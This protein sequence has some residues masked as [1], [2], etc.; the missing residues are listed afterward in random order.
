MKRACGLLCLL[1]SLLAAACSPTSGPGSSSQAPPERVGA[2]RTLIFVH[3]GENLSYA[4]KEIQ[5][6]GGTTAGTRTAE[7][8]YLFNANLIFLDD[9]SLPYAVLAESVPEFGTSS[10]QLLPD[11]KMEI[12]Y[13][14]KPN[15]TWHDGQ[16][17]T[18][19]DWAFAWRVYSN[20][21]FGI[22]SSGGLRYIDDVIA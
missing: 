8:K 20:P 21:V 1:G 16:P 14:L 11:G 7:A 4:M 19:D 3:G 18:A 22:A 12:T 2:G 17:L 10:W 15:L 13:R 6:A 5:P 9:R